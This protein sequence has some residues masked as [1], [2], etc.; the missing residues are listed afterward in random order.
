MLIPRLDP[1]MVS[2]SGDDFEQW[3]LDTYEWLGLV[4]LQSPRVLQHDT[5]DPYLG[6][7]KVPRVDSEP[8]ANVLVGIKWK[9]YFP[10]RWIRRLIIE[11]KYVNETLI[12]T[13]PVYGLPNRSC[14]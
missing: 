8:N 6:R 14:D 2:K 4:S 3:A 7:Y 1:A 10:T 12:A 9:G 13:K 11:L 5:L